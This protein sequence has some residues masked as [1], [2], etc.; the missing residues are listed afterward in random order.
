M[1]ESIEKKSESVLEQA[2]RELAEETRKVNVK[3][4]KNKLKELQLAQTAFENIKREV[5]DLE[6]SISDGN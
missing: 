2:E 4:L 1:V 3:R 5:Q 6:I